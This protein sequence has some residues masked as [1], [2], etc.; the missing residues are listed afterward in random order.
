M[1]NKK[2]KKKPNYYGR[3]KKLKA[4]AQKDARRG[5][6]QDAAMEKEKSKYPVEYVKQFNG[7]DPQWYFK[8]S[9]L[10]R[11]VASFSFEKPLGTTV[12]SGNNVSAWN[13]IAGVM[14]VTLVPTVGI[15]KDA[16]SP[17]NLAAQNIYT[18]VRYKN[19]G[20]ANYDAPDLM[21]YYV[22]MSSLY[23]VWNWA[24]RIYGYASEYKA[25]NYY[26][27]WAYAALDNVDL[28]NIVMNLA[29]FRSYLNM[30]ADRISAFV[31]PSVFSYMTRQSWLY[32]NIYKDSDT[33]KAQEY[34]FVP[35]LFYTF[36]EMT[37]PKGSQLV[38]INVNANVSNIKWN[39][40]SIAGLIDTMINN[41][42]YSSDIGNMSGDTL[43]E[44]GESRFVLSHFE[45][46]Y[47]CEAVYNREV[48]TQFENMK[49]LRSLSSLFVQTNPDLSPLNITHDP[50]TN[51]IEY[52]PVYTVAAGEMLKPGMHLNFHWSN[53]SPEDVIV[54][55]RLNAEFTA[56]D[57]DAG[58]ITYTITSCG[59]EIP[60]AVRVAHYTYGDITEEYDALES[61]T[62]AVDTLD[63]VVFGNP[64]ASAPTVAG[65]TTR[66]IANAKSISLQSAFDWAPFLAVEIRGGSEITSPFLVGIPLRDWDVYTYVGETQM[67]SMNTLA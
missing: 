2:F 1:A 60:I 14:G 34:M 42:Q 56:T 43:K 20:A 9:D 66:M 55:S 11:D 27:A 6:F 19:S 23:S 54:A 63:G 65:L 41:L 57:P 25:T 24:K 53:P 48:L 45:P 35:G 40:N 30:A 32:S 67:D 31:V 62:L 64:S 12:L 3:A 15:S 51:Y 17:I 7:N 37:S 8:S 44:F 52:Q 21:M 22:G 28:T 16:Q 49:W 10:L 36:D 61:K 26:K 33:T 39:V 18:R 50:N 47:K 5:N 46:D 13:S 59:S 58:M 29:N 38:A 4:E